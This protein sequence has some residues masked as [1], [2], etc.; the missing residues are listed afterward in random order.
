L[1]LIERRAALANLAAACTQ[2]R[3]CVAGP[4]ALAG[5]LFSWA[6]LL[7]RIYEI[8]PLRCALCAAQMRLIAFLTDP[9]A[10]TTILAHLAEP[11]THPKCHAN[12]AP[13]CGT[14][15]SS[16]WP[17]AIRSQRPCPHLW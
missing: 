1:E 3:Q 12:V 7:A 8:L 2:P 10:V 5:S 15:C 14:R 13:R 16:R 9:L 6:L 17:T 4:R 11:T